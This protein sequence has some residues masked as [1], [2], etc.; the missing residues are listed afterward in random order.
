M[1]LNTL[2][3]KHA[4]PAEKTYALP[5]GDGLQLEI[6]PEGR[7]HWRYR[8]QL[9]GHRNRMSFGSYPDVGLKDARGM[10]MAAEELIARGIDPV[11]QKKQG[12]EEHLVQLPAPV[13]FELGEPLVY[14]KM[15][16]VPTQLLAQF[17]GCNVKN[18]KQ[19]YK[20]NEARFVEGKHY[21]K[22][23]GEALREIKRLASQRGQVEISTQTPTVLLWTER[24][25]A[26]HAKMLETDAAWD[27]FEKLE[28]AYF[29][30]EVT[31]AVEEASDGKKYLHRF[32]DMDVITSLT[33][34]KELQLD[35]SHVVAN[36]F[37]LEQPQEIMDLNFPIGE[38]IV[39]GRERVSVVAMTQAGFNLLM[40]HY[41]GKRVD[42][43]RVRVAE[44]FALCRPSVLS[45]N[46]V[47]KVRPRFAKPCLDARRMLA[48]KGALRIYAVV[49]NRTY[50][51][52]SGEL[53]SYF[54]LARLEDLGL[55]SYEIALDY[56]WTGIE[57]P[58]IPNSQEEILCSDA[59]ASVLRGALDLW[60]YHAD[61]RPYEKV[62]EE[63]EATTGIASPD[64]VPEK[65]VLKTLLIIWGK[66]SVA[67]ALKEA[68]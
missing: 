41:S 27:V 45:L 32:V 37:A 24:G 67:L 10:R 38:E 39:Q 46:S 21:F 2:K 30:R 55:E 66:L 54:K 50:E 59:N 52:T 65:D 22:L 63:F 11:E 68:C 51:E 13:E 17:Y 33:I 64:F 29:N 9:N 12:K 58:Y 15:P 60:A 56:V 18:I 25:A 40:Q 28:D 16:V 31:K 6:T 14:R 20:R 3:I 7:K 1:K 49:E 5:D 4:K 44:E 62:M 8:Y 43:F 53:C 19:N 36:V 34:A 61:T 47:E 26:R 23:E 48:L 57:R 35:H 42:Q